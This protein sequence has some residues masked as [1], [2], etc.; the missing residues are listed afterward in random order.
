MLECRAR[1][2]QLTVAFSIRELDQ[3]DIGACRYQVCLIDRNSVRDNNAPRLTETDYYSAELKLTLAKE[4]KETS[5]RTSFNT[6]D[7]VYLLKR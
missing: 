5:G 1:R 2:S 3:L 7:K 4:F 6:F